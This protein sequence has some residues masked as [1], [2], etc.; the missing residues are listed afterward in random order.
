AEADEILEAKP[1]RDE[2]VARSH[3]TDQEIG[4]APA[5]GFCDLVRE[6]LF[7]LKFVWTGQPTAVEDTLDLVEQA[8]IGPADLVVVALDQDQLGSA[9]GHMLQLRLSTM[10]WREDE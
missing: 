2:L 3:R 8:P 7:A 1:G 4:G 6:R 5:K 9:G 10:A